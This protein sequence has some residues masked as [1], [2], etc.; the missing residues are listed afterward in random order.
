MISN[1]T[2]N[3][4]ACR[5]VRDLMSSLHAFAS[6]C[7]GHCS[8]AGLP[9]PIHADADGWHASLDSGVLPLLPVKNETTTA[10]TTIE[11][12]VNDGS[13]GD[14]SSGKS[15][16]F[17]RHEGQGLSR[18]QSFSWPSIGQ[19]NP[20]EMHE[21]IRTTKR[22][23]GPARTIPSKLRIGWAQWHEEADSSKHLM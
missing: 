15:Q 11:V 6:L 3:I 12:L 7:E 8:L 21:C 23:L 14:G 4:L 9:V 13:S 22:R 2:E 1:I 18:H 20:G 5:N 16:N 19:Y 17:C 10:T